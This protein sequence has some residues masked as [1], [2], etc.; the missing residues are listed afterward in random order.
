MFI[1]IVVITEKDVEMWHSINRDGK[2]INFPLVQDLRLKSSQIADAI[3]VLCKEL[4]TFLDFKGAPLRIHILQYLNHMIHH[5]SQPF[6]DEYGH[7]MRSY[8]KVPIGYV[9]YAYFLVQ[10]YGKANQCSTA[11]LLITTERSTIT[12]LYHF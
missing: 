7:E 3:E 5:R 9:K 6:N 10:L 8:K 1:S 4:Q 12:A 2:S 11:T